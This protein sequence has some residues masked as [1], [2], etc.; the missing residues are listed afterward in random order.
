MTRKVDESW[1]KLQEETFL[2]W[3]N[4]I[5]KGPL[6]TGEIQVLDLKVDFKDGRALT[7]LLDNLSSEDKRVKIWNKNPKI[8]VQMREN[9]TACF[10]FMD[11]EGIYLVNI[12]PGD[13]FDGNVKLELGLIWTLIRHYQ[14]RSSGK[15]F[16]T[17]EAMLKWVNTLIPE[18]KITNFTTDWNNGLALCA[19]VNRIQPGLIPHHETLKP[20]NGLENCTLG[21][22][23]A[24]E[25]LDIAY[26]VK[27]EHLNN[28]AVDELIVMTYISLFCRPSFKLILEWVRSKI[29]HQNVTNF[30]TDWNDGINL[31]ALI[32]AIS[33]GL[34]PSWS[35]LDPHNALE[36]LKQ[37]MDVAEQKLGV[38][39]VLK[40]NEMADP[41]VD[42][43]NVVTY[44]SRFQNIKAIPLPERCV[45]SGAG[46]TKAFVR[47]KTTFQVDS[48]RA[49][50][51]LLG[52][53]ISS[54]SGTKID[55]ATIEEKTGIYKV[56][57][58]P[59]EAGKTTIAIK[60]GTSEITSSPFTCE[61]VDTGQISFSGPQITEGHS[62]KVG[63]LIKMLAKGV[64]EL[65]EFQVTIQHPSGQTQPAKLAPL[66]KDQVECSYTPS[67]AGIDKVI[68]KF[69]QQEI[70]GSPFDVRVVDPS[71]CSV[72]CT[73]PPAGQPATVGKS[74]SFTIKC[75]EVSA[76]GILVECKT[77]TQTFLIPSTS[78]KDSLLAT[79]SPLET[80]IHTITVTCAGESIKG[81]PISLS[82]ID[83][84]KAVLLD[85]V[86]KSLQ[87]GKE[88]V[89][90]VSS[91][92][93]G[94]G[95]LEVT[96]S[97][98]SVISATLQKHTEDTYSLN[99]KAV[100][101]GSS[102][103]NITWSNQSIPKC[104][105]T[106]SS[107]DA[108]KVVAYGKGLGSGL[109]KVEEL[110]TFTVQTKNAG[111]G[112]LE[113]TPV[114]PTNTSFA[115][116]KESGDGTYDVSFTSYEAGPHNINIS[117]GGQAIPK[118]PFAVNFV[119][120]DANQFSARGEGLK[121]C[122]A[123]ASTQ[124]IL[125]G[126]EAGLVDSKVL[127]VSITGKGLKC[128]VVKSIPP[129]S[130][131]ANIL[132]SYVDEG[133]GNY[134]VN[135]AVPKEGDY[136]INITCSKEPISGSP[137]TLHA[138][139]A[140]DASKCRM[141]GPA[142]DEPDNLVI[143][144]PL[145]F[146]VDTT[147]GGTGKISA[148]AFDPNMKPVPLFLAEEKGNQKLHLLKIDPEVM[149]KHMFEV[150]WAGTHV[151]KSPITFEVGDASKVTIVSIPDQETF[152]AKA[153]E[154]FQV[155]VDTSQAG[156]GKLNA[157]AKISDN[158]KQPFVIK[159]SS[160]GQYS[161][162]YSPSK[163]VTKIE[164][165]LTYGGINVLKAPWAVDVVNASEM[166]VIPFEGYGKVGEYVKFNIVG[167]MKKNTI[168]KTTVTSNHEK[169]SA[170]VKTDWSKTG[171]H[172]TRFTAKMMGQY[173]VEVVCGQQHISGSPFTVQIAN[174][175]E[176]KLMGSLP[177]CLAL[178]SSETVTFDKSKCGPGELTATLDEGTSLLTDVIDG[179]TVILN[180]VGVGTC[181]LS[182]K[183]AGYH[184]GGTPID[185][186]V[187]DPS[188]CTFH[189]PQLAGKSIVKENE[190][191]EVVVDVTKSGPC[192]PE[193]KLQGPKAAYNA[194]SFV[195]NK[196]GTFT[197]TFAPWQIGRHTLDILVG[198]QKVPKSGVV[199]DVLKK[200]DLTQIRATG[201]FEALVGQLATVTILGLE[202]GSL[203]RGQLTYKVT[204][205][206]DKLPTVKCED[207]SNST[208]T[209]S[210]TAQEKGEYNVEILYEGESIQGSPFTIK[211]KPAP[212]ADKCQASGPVTEP[213]TFLKL[214]D[215]GQIKVNTTQAGSGELVAKGKQPDGR[216]LRIFVSE[217]E[218]GDNH[219]IFDT[220]IVGIYTIIVEWDGSA[221]PGSPFSIPVV[222]PSRCCI[223]SSIP[224]TVQLNET[225]SIVID[226]TGA[227][228]SS[229]SVLI[230]GSESSKLLNA[231]IV[232]LYELDEINENMY[233]V[234][235]S[236]KD[237]GA[238]NVSIKWGSFD[239]PKTP[240]PL[241]ICDS[242][243]CKVDAIEMMKSPLQVGVPFS[244]KVHTKGAGNTK[245]QV[246]PEESSN[247]QYTID[248]QSSNDVQTATCTPWTV[249]TQ[250]LL[251]MWGD[252]PLPDSPL[253]F[254]VCDPRK[255]KIVGL[256]ESASYTAAIGEEISFSIDYSEAGPGKPN[257]V[258]K[259]AESS[260]E[261]T[262]NGKLIENEDKIMGFTYTPDKPG[263]LELMMDYSGINI[264]EQPWSC[265]VPDPTQ[266]RVSP[267]KGLGRLGEPV[268]FIITGVTKQNQNF[269]ITATHKDQTASITTEHGKDENTIIAYFTPSSI[270]DYTVEVK[271]RNHSVDG[272][273]FVTQVSN[274]SNVKV[275]A[276]PSEVVPVGQKNVLLVDSNW[277][278]PG[279]LSCHVI[280]LSGQFEMEPQII[281]S[282]DEEG[283]Y[284]IVLECDSVGTCS[285][286][287]KWAE[288][289][290]ETF[291]INIVDPSKV[292][293]SCDQL[294]NANS[295]KQG[296]SLKFGV[297]CCEAGQGAPP[298]VEVTTTDPTSSTSPVPI[299]VQDN[300]DGTF[301]LI[302]SPW[303]AG[304][305]HMTVTWN[306]LV[307]TDPPIQFEVRKL[308]DSRG[309]TAHGD[310]L[311]FALAGQ[312]S[313][314]VV[315][316]SEVG[317]VDEGLL[318]AKCFDPEKVEVAKSEE[319]EGEEDK[320]G[321][322]EMEEA[323]GEKEIPQTEILLGADE[324]S[325]KPAPVTSWKDNKDGMYDLSI[326]YPYEG[327]FILSI[328]YGGQPIY[329]SPFN[330]VVKG[331]P[332]ADKCIISGSSVERLRKGLACPLNQQIEI[333]VD[334]T[335]AGDGELKCTAVD[336]SNEIVRVFTH[337][338]LT[339]GRQLHYL[340]MGL[341]DV[342]VYTVKLYWS[343]EPLPETPL[344][345]SVVD[346]TRC[347]IE[348]LPI[349]TGTMQEGEPLK[350]SIKPNG[351]GEELPTVTITT[352]EQPEIPIII[353][354][355][356]SED[357]TT[358]IYYYELIQ[359]TIYTIYVTIG[360]I[361]ILG[362]PFKCE[363]VDL[364]QFM[365]SGWNIQGDYAF[366]GDTVSFVINGT[367]PE[368]DTFTV[369]AHGP[370]ND[371]ECP[372]QL[373]EDGSYECSFPVID[374]GSYEVYVE[375]A[376]QQVKNSPFKVNVADPSKCQAMEV[377]TVL[378]VGVKEQIIVKT[379][380]AGIGKLTV[381]I[382]G[383]EESEALSV[384]VEE[385]GLDTQK[386]TLE[387][388]K[389]EEIKLDI[390][391]GGKSIPGS[392][393]N[394]NICDA[395]Q[396]KAF[397][398]SLMSRKGKVG[399][400][401]I[402][403]I[404]THK[405]GNAKLDIR[406]DGP[407]AQY[408][409][410]STDVGD[411]KYEAHF[412][413]WQVGVH[414]I[415]VYWGDKQIPKS[416]FIINVD[417][418]SNNEL[419]CHAT[420]DGLKKAI[421]TKP[422]SFTLFSSVPGLVD[423]G[424][425]NVE[426]QSALHGENVPVKIKDQTDG[427]YQV[428][429]IPPSRGAYLAN[430]SFMDNPIPGSPF[431][432]NC[433]ASPEASKCHV[434][435]LHQ[436]TL[437]VAGKPV[438]FNVDCSKGGH[439]QLRVYV[440]GP[441]DQH[442]KVYLADDGKG[443]YSVKFDTV[444]PGRYFI[445][446]AWSDTHIPG[447]P[448]KIRVYPGPDASKVK[449]TGPGI[450]D[451]ILGSNNDMYID[452]KEAG[453]GTLLIRVHGIK[454]AFKIQADPLNES[455]PRILLATYSP[456][457]SGNYD[458]FIRWSGV[459]VPG[460]PFK[461]MVHKRPGDDS[462][463][464]S[465]DEE[466]KKKVA[467]K[468]KQ[469]VVKEQHRKEVKD[470]GGAKKRGGKGRLKTGSTGAIEVKKM[471]SKG[472]TRSQSAVGPIKP[473]MK[474]KS[475]PSFG[476]MMTTEEG[477]IHSQ[478]QFYNQ[479][480][481]MISAGGAGVVHKKVVIEKKV[482]KHARTEMKGATKEETVDSSEKAGQK[483]KKRYFELR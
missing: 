209:L 134:L 94:P 145:E 348:G 29:P 51:G 43:L 455:E 301:D 224:D 108:S 468:R 36:N 370:H 389:V 208:Y 361:S 97:D 4:S 373:K 210:Y 323:D 439:G 246:R 390:L 266:F 199:F 347:G 357:G 321:E 445:V 400:D 363:V 160:K 186:S 422:T 120:T 419:S 387:P 282:P 123:K 178:D 2:N 482:K 41:N 129:V 440:Q 19:L 161:C 241:S 315:N 91:K 434:N 275:V 469:M 226:T 358:Y 28:P 302:I 382:N 222:D 376:G 368:G 73:E 121:E 393:L 438:E 256:P 407:S 159:K 436:N 76:H 252:K 257:V 128:N 176:C 293:I 109:G 308:I 218:S 141:F 240:F 137:F 470:V 350:F 378:H 200:I 50:V 425:L 322:T 247:A 234:N 474:M 24:S 111:K 173:T 243:A 228:A 248:I 84:K 366:V 16:S 147:N 93:A 255:C 49:G 142:I 187:V 405:A 338:E 48:T 56:S 225:K 119:K 443:V 75:D 191:V 156:P 211:I 262:V 261:V 404:I 277:A 25:G 18:H 221:I 413:P 473:Q 78:Q 164:L 117:W 45:A 46:L 232:D 236:G 202:P 223:T 457:R 472:V 481:M 272:S 57:Y 175:N 20:E 268:R 412:T 421:A 116:I 3:V 229:L 244:F 446:I 483:K 250:S 462:S 44:I 394:L 288:F 127:E 112:H 58:T 38:E 340:K 242:G 435:G 339:D 66:G 13:L 193:V 449:V 103:V 294:E 318:V 95:K 285:V 163:E 391:W 332:S 62:G 138:L 336:S 171:V 303:Q 131:D 74:A 115:E 212:C 180:P 168:K 33:P 188:K 254:N 264:L 143:G 383:E 444:T 479:S 380:E 125:I 27:A 300:K 344:V 155:V 329:Q 60:W 402:F 326:T 77:Q 461:V 9:L 283:Q 306:G 106:V 477:G 251:V 21:M 1:Q 101:I 311:K 11:S 388:L 459:H 265:D 196:N 386:V 105:F 140:P 401:V 480:G 284:E 169:H 437:Y 110:F 453:I 7:L 90:K 345:F 328:E 448:F 126:P 118:S 292:Q 5:L 263:R 149:G 23:V 55:A 82:V 172:V 83:T 325:E 307:I 96:S 35:S 269:S 314:I 279:E 299:N 146:K 238:V 201:T 68:V 10:D 197:A 451:S 139:P 185:I 276:P 52:I 467:V 374:A 67:K 403:T 278:G 217:D 471:P 239:V 464:S 450:Q 296:E 429:Y 12:G 189:S 151:P 334:S 152:V 289:V 216:N 107:C 165:I 280:K 270:G 319:E 258:A 190:Q 184:V 104:P 47:R 478:Q 40:P 220:P 42:E 441:H 369:M 14:I 72:T 158:D 245:L 414:T 133:S 304:D 207:N 420:G 396:C 274:P 8:P 397:G 267:P 324:S 432:I 408:T 260:E 452:T 31:A 427:S 371:Q 98:A 79:Y 39:P 375:C 271:H 417:K 150:K 206:G 219:L 355:T 237:I 213:G 342:G 177:Q 331:A 428:V 174:P 317:L 372:V 433:V 249:G 15:V 64:P 37:G 182:I 379:A 385:E 113:V 426:V 465:S 179:D 291:N 183:W 416:P 70:S 71:K 286:E 295:I 458:I 360:G 92:G 406:A 316:A 132:V 114:G 130:N 337:E 59:I 85:A 170:T 335:D 205:S 53:Q 466:G 215:Q 333:I 99:L 65:S 69:A 398:Q 310:G 341:H 122:I 327:E 377:P 392:P 447:S 305:Y 273:P 475:N 230:D 102:N 343:D 17:K 61:V 281:S 409:I 167:P 463:S 364:S 367:P 384:V 154:S 63:Q 356:L 346:I 194:T 135:Y 290:I 298:K 423:K 351:C 476:Q 365:V 81:S 32:E 460:S 259:L 233:Q 148:V 415:E 162:T 192:S 352:Q 442:P 309:I 89:L 454:D 235:L 313:V 100:Q 6:K 124:F 157:W 320:E 26:I 253:N 204:G 359:V 362:T 198:G 166:K 136:S 354:G 80:G 395:K 231:D 22:Q 410:T 144:N 297:N 411:N 153:G 430:I 349:S 330:I 87:V 287:L 195:D 86:P 381:T 424:L 418:G 181:K 30:K 399:E 227:G 456:T 88:A 312:T 353:E 214:K 203:E 34:F 431:K 54:P